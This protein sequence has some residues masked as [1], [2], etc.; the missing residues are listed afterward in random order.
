M[1]LTPA[2]MFVLA[3]DTVTHWIS[4]Y[5]DLRV[6][7]Q[8]SLLSGRKLNP[9]KSCCL[10]RIGLHHTD[11]CNI[12]YLYIYTYVSYIMLHNHAK[13]MPSHP[14]FETPFF[15]SVFLKGTPPTGFGLHNFRQVNSLSSIPKEPNSLAFGY[16]PE[17]TYPTMGKGKSSSKGIFNGIC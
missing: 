8:T 2:T 11:S 1:H 12:F 13:H 5:P 9:T 6:P 14:G 15:W 17:L 10:D 16:T 3:A 7:K 4:N